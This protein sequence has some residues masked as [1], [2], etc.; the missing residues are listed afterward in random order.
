MHGDSNVPGIG[1]RSMFQRALELFNH[2]FYWEAHEAW[3]HVWIEY[4]KR[5]PQA[6]FI[7]GL[8]KLSACGVKCLEGNRTGAERHLRRAVELLDLSQSAKDSIDSFGV[9][10]TELLQ[11][12]STL[13]TNLPIQNS[14]LEPG[15][16]LPILGTIPVS[17]RS[18]D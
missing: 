12:I 2:G 11:Q 18:N 15:P 3:E 7:K 5:G 1:P 17:G 10:I 14:E 8:I 16:V 13:E 6:D 9:S 4:G